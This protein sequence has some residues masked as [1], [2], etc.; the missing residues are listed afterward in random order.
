MPAFLKLNTKQKTIILVG[1]PNILE[2]IF[3]KTNTNN[4]N[5]PRTLSICVQRMYL[6]TPAKAI[7]S[8]KYRFHEFFRGL[9]D[10]IQF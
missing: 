6:I 10:D 1:S 5:F 4:H 2:S 9:S 3:Y 7:P 8:N